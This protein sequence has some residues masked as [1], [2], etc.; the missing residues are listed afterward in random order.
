[1]IHPSMSL[2]IVLKVDQ[3]LLISVDSQIGMIGHF[4]SLLFAL[5]ST[6]YIYK[7]K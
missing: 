3:S 6:I 5:K 1:M 2:V 7:N 4:V